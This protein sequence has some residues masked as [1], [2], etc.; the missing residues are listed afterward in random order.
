M[1]AESSGTNTRPV[2][3][4]ATDSVRYGE[5]F[6]PRI[7]VDDEWIEQLRTAL[8]RLP[9]I[10]VARGAVLVDGYHRW[11][12]HVREGAAF[13]DAEDLG[14]LTDDEIFW[15]AV[16]LNSMHGKQLSSREKRR[17]AEIRYERMDPATAVRELAARLSVDE[18]SVQR[19]T[20]DA[21]AAVEQDRQATAWSL[22][23]DCF[24]QEQIAE[25]LGVTHQ[26][27][28]KWLATRRQLSS[29]CDDLPPGA[30]DERPWGNVQHFDIWNFQSADKDAGQ[31]SYFGALPPQVIENILWFWTEPGQIIVDP[32]AGSGTTV[33]VAKAMGRRVWASDIRGS[34]Y[35]PHLPIHEHDMGTGWPDDAPAKADLIL[36]DPPYWQQAAGRYSSEPGEMA[37][38]NLDTFYAAWAQVAKT[39]MEHSARI[40]YIISPTQCGDGTVVD[41]ATEMITPFTDGGWRV[42]RRIIVPYQTQQATGQQVNWARE[43]KRLLKLYRDLVVMSR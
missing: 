42:E 10:K 8:D 40:A 13:I 4:I 16:R 32:F 43:N 31:Q 36:L 38:M 15:E 6:Q 34:H 37:E 11:Q 35:S 25:R 28:S 17:I 30:T 1:S 2:I 19:W 3:T 18:R 29:G 27:V 26:A 24:T 7:Q 21:R 12:A 20:K 14:D 39:C 41:H 9:P 33:D 5:E 22:H 23:L